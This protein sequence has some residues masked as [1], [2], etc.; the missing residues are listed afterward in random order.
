CS[1]ANCSSQLIIPPACSS[2]GTAAGRWWR[3]PCREWSNC[4]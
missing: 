2:G 3:H 4:H 1:C